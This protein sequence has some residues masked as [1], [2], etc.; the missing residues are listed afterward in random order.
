MKIKLS[1]LSLLLTFTN[2]IAHAS[3][4]ENSSNYNFSGSY[5]G[6]FL[7]YCQTSVKSNDLFQTNYNI[8]NLR[9]INGLKNKS[10]LSGKGAQL[11]IFFGYGR[12]YELLYIGAEIDAAL[13]KIKNST[14]SSFQDAGGTVSNHNI[15][16]TLKGSYAMSIKVGRVLNDNSLLYL[17]TGAIVSHWGLSSFYPSI[18]SSIKNPMYKTKKRHQAGVLLGTGIDFAINHKVIASAEVNYMQYKKIH[19]SHPRMN[20]GSLSPST[21]S[22]GLKLSYK[23]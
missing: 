1:F 17:K 6:T 5:I 10:N 3:T 15:S 9:A 14:S 18:T 12:Q 7:G 8:T 2:T 11:G 20:K 13:Q 19:Y 21:F 4:S 16:T 22:F 23:I